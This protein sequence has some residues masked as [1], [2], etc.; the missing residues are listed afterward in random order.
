M[1]RL[2]A[3]LFAVAVALPVAADTQVVCSISAQ[4]ETACSAITVSQAGQFD[5]CRCNQSGGGGG[6]A[7][8]SVYDDAVSLWKLDEASDGSAPVTRADSIGSNDLTDN[9]TVASA[10]KGVGAPANL[11]DNVASFAA[12]NT[13]YLSVADGPTTVWGESGAGATVSLWWKPDGAPASYGLLFGRDSLDDADR[14]FN[15]YVDG[16]GSQNILMEF[17]SGSRIQTVGSNFTEGAWNHLVV[18]FDPADNKQRAYLNGTLVLTSTAGASSSLLSS[19]DAAVVIGGWPTLS[20]FLNGA[21]SSVAVWDYVKDADGVAALYNS[22]DGAT[23][24]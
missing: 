1:K 10:A 11:P 17:N 19:A 24:P 6:G 4:A 23:L 22:G 5:Q 16:A 9:N 13:E 20:G 18:T 21:V 15:V 2:L 12:A 8:P 14:T 7:E 3:V